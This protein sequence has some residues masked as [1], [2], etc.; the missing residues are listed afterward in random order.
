VEATAE[1]ATARATAAETAGE[2]TVAGT[3]VVER[4]AETGEGAMD[5]ATLE[6]EEG[7]LAGSRV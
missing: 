4:E 3:E 1:W 2:E 6:K 7:T 5:E